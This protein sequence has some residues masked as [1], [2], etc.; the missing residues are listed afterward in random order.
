MLFGRSVMTL[1]NSM[2]YSPP[3]YSV[4]EF[5][6]QEYWSRLP[7]PSP[8]D[9]PKPG[10]EPGSP[11]LQVDSLLTE[12]PGKPKSRMPSPYHICNILIQKKY[13]LFPWKSSLAGQPVFY[14]TVQL[15]GCLNVFP[16]WQ[17]VFPRA[18]DPREREQRG[19]HNSFYGLVLA[20][21]HFYFH[22]IIYSL[23]ASQ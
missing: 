20:V 23:E 6:R 22:R 12:P 10:I 9:L 7:F 1:C 14:L 13:S 11:A 15:Q 3:G 21:S 17:L 18:Y 4:H 19:N 8:E 16:T 2:D 5:S